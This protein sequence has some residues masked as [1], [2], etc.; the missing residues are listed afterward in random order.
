MVGMSERWHP[1]VVGILLLGCSHHEEPRRGGDTPSPDVAS[2]LQPCPPGL[3]TKTV[4]EVLAQQWPRGACFA[5]RGR[6][7]ATY[8]TYLPEVPLAKPHP[9][10]RPADPV[11]GPFVRA[12]VLTDPDDPASPRRDDPR[13]DAQPT[14][15][16]SI[17]G[18]YETW[19]LPLLRCNRGVDGNALMP[20][21][22]RL[23]L[24]RFALSEV[25]RLNEKLVGMNVVV[26]G[27]K[28]ARDYKPEELDDFGM[29]VI[30]HVCRLDA[31]SAP[32]PPG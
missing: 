9:P 17:T 15:G 23:E 24:P 12:W 3:R 6:L 22:T 8:G 5:V 27:G 30:T 31:P 14:I 13:F 2:A 1:L 26:F 4:R 11:Q 7:S 19:L 16:L 32:S 10:P 28:H 18:H 21:R 20:A 25:A 29:M